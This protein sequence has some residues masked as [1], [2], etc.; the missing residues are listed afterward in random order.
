[1]SERTTRVA[2][3]GIITQ[4]DE[5]L[6]SRISAIN[7]DKGRWTLPG[8]GIDFGENL[9]DALAREIHEETGLTMRSAEI[10]HTEDQYF[11]RDQDPV[12]AIRLVY[13]VEVEEGQPE[14]IEVDG[15]TDVCGYFPIDALPECVP[16]VGR[17][18]RVAFPAR[19]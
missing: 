15:S 18:I 5:L 17:A 6:L 12:H 13:R 7:P 2:C 8:G 3:Y 9:M 10:I 11:G 16:M 4:G 1:M 14:V 19:T